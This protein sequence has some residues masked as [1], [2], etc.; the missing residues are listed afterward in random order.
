MDLDS[1]ILLWHCI[2]DMVSIDDNWWAVM[3]GKTEVMQRHK[4][5]Q[6]F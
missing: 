1:V 5:L 3:S 2:D 4:I 6:R